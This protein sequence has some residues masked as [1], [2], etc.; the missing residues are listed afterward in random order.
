[1]APLEVLSERES[2]YRL[3]ATSTPDNLN[4]DIK[5][6]TIDPTTRYCNLNKNA[7]LPEQIRN[8]YDDSNDDIYKVHTSKITK[9][10]N[11]Q[12]VSFNKGNI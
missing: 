3:L 5:C 9:Q 7:I 6:Y 2:I 1:M 11:L 12:G 8:L 10:T 4:K